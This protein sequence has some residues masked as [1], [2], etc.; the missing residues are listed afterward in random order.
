MNQQQ[1]QS[2]LRTIKAERL[3]RNPLI[4][5]ESAPTIGDNINGPSVIRVPD[6]IENPLGRYYMYFAHHG[7]DHIRLAYAD[8]PEGPW[9]VY[10]PGTLQLEQA[11]A[12]KHHIASPD[13]HV[14]HERREL[15][16]YYHGIAKDRPGQWSSMATSKDGIK[17]SSRSEILGKFYLRVWKWQD[18][19]YGIAKSDNAGWGQVLRSPDGLQPFE[20]REPFLMGMRHCAVHRMG[21]TLLVIYS[22]VGDEPERLLATIIDLRPDWTEWAPAEPAELLTPEMPWE[23]VDHPLEPSQFG[24]ATGVRQLRD[25]CIFADGDTLYL[26]YS[27]AGEEGIAGA[28]LHVQGSAAV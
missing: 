5:P 24:P 25:P 28:R 27:F 6:W 3:P 1:M 13:V 7:G 16:M 18:A 26:Y 2:I 10:E 15:R 20:A 19:Y 17:F 14:D 22:R 8:A 12:M 21:H 23:G 4:T 9:T 11:P